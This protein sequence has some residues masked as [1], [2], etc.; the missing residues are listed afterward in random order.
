V[1]STAAHTTRFLKKGV[2]CAVLLVGSLAHLVFKYHFYSIVKQ[3]HQL[4]PARDVEQT[5][6]AQG[7]R[8]AASVPSIAWA[9]GWVQRMVS[10]P[11]KV[12][13]YMEKKDIIIVNC[14]AIAVRTSHI[15]S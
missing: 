5:C 13:K 4:N 15:F 1:Q 2:L 3:S 9:P 11:F 12:N 7:L 10:R 14:I 8:H 6:G